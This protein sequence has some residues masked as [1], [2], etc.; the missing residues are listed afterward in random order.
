MDTLVLVK[1]VRRP[2]N[3][4]VNVLNVSRRNVTSISCG[5]M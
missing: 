2:P 1:D 3:D 4:T 5:K